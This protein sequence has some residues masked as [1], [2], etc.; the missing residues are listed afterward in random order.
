MGNSKSVP[1]MVDNWPEGDITRARELSCVKKIEEVGTM[2]EP[3]H[4]PMRV[5]FRGLLSLFAT[6]LLFLGLSQIAL[7]QSQQKWEQALG[8]ARQEGKVVVWGPPGELIRNAVV[9]G[10]QKAYPAITIEFTGGR[11][12]S[13]AAKVKAERD[14]GVYS[15][16]VMLSGTTT[17]NIYLEPIK[18]L[19]PIEPALLLPEVTDLKYWSNHSLEFSDESSRN[20]LV[21]VNQLKTPL[22]YNPNTAKIE[23]IDS[24]FELLAP[25]WKGKYVIND[26]VPSG[27]GNVTFRWLWRVLGPEKATDYY[28]RFRAN[29]GAVDRDQRRQ[30]EW[31]AQGKYAFAFGPSDGTMQ[32]L[33][34]R[35][36]KFDVLPEFEEGSL[37]TASFGSVMVIN[38]APHPNAATV[39]LNWIL[40]KEGQTIWSRAMNHHSRRLDVPQDHLPPYVIP[41]PGSGVYSGDPKPGDR[42]WISHSAEN[43]HRTPEETKILQELFGR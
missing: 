12:G 43:V 3:C 29:A 38:R 35:G 5:L 41:K 37:I 15:V 33:L 32:Q 18:A 16:D 7:A 34:Q 2:N 24:I 27:A 1:A 40:T 21:F 9:A 28:R 36:L 26:P 10:F 23:E 17:A 11:G 22:I 8:A 14:G 39:F 4:V 6:A 13:H 19:D 42:Y 30:I 25:K 20:N 31:I